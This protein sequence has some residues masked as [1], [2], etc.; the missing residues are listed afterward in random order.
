MARSK[1]DHPKRKLSRKA[2]LKQVYKDSKKQIISIIGKDK[3]QDLSNELDNKDDRDLRWDN[4]YLYYTQLGRSMYSLKPIDISELMN[5]NLYDQD[6]IFPKS[7]NMMIL[8][9]IEF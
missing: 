6:H 9:K 5:K 8:L 1:E 3:Y 7:K 2:D 4:L